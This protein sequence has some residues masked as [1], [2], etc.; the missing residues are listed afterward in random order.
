MSTVAPNPS[1]P[2]APP[3][4]PTAET[5]KIKVD[6]R[7]IEV[8]KMMPDWQGK[9]AAT[10]M[11]QACQLAG[12]DVPHYCYHPKLPIAGNCRMCLVEF[13]LPMMGPDRKLMLNED[14]TP[15]IAKQVLPYEPSQP[16]GAIACATPISPG[17]EIY[18]SSPA[19]KQMREGVLEGLLIN[20]PLD[21]PICDQ[22]GECKLQEYSVQYGQAESRFVETK[23][24][25]PKAVDLGPRIVLDDERCILCTRCI[26]FTKDIVGDDKLGIVNRGS[27]NT[28]AAYPG[29]QFDNN[30]TL[31][32]VDI[33]PVG[34]LTS[35]DFRFKMRVWFLKETKS[36]CTSCATGC[37][38]IVSSREDRVYR[39]EPRQ[40]E[41][42]NSCWMCDYGRLN[43]KWINREDRLTDVIAQ[44]ERTTWTNALGE[45]GQKLR[46]AAPGSVAL[47]ASARQCNEE[48]F[49]LK[50]LAD[51]V[52]ALTDSI[53]RTDVGDHLLLSADRNPNSRAAALM[54]LSAAP[55]GSRIASIAEGIRNGTIKTLIVFGEDVTRHGIGEDLLGRLE[56][57]VVC[58]ILPGGTTRRA[59]YLLPG[60]AHVEKHG[61]FT[62]GKGRVQRFLKAS[63][64][65]GSA[66]P[67][68]EFLHE[69][70]FSVTG[71]NGFV[72][73][74][75]LFNQMAREIPAFNGLTWA[76]LGDLG[77]NLAS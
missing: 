74:E 61:S 25:K 43:Y 31:N 30:Y 69:L 71:Q 32:T 51:K 36:I 26:R 8:P 56:T 40:N 55:V 53:P 28:L 21:C 45:V 34:A 48:L 1:K 4:A 70:V 57:L 39:Y 42:V 20:H 29:T 5:I 22:A 62:N 59:H 6:G 49:L 19:T 47:I 60:C 72:N 63:E 2:A 9:P 64:P 7:E 50:K 11:L 58:D 3:T 77:V 52:G 66:R 67:E 27:Y 38:I 12:V 23:V 46:S 65:P 37:N 10:T 68:W 16:R 41:A 76:A 15:K 18:P 54:G 44:G 35:K 73:I 33:C 24:H 17:M 13:G 14:G 75:G